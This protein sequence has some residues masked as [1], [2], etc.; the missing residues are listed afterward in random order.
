M[1]KLRVGIIGVGVINGAIGG[2]VGVGVW[3][4]TNAAGIDRKINIITKTRIKRRVFIN[5][6]NHQQDARNDETQEKNDADC[7]WLPS[8]LGSCPA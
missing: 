5:M 1:S 4:C 2:G 8:F 6:K 7:F 3:A